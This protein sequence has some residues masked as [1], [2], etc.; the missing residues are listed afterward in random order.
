MPASK[1]NSSR[2]RFI[3]Y[4]L[5]VTIY[6]L[7]IFYLSSIPGKEIPL[8]FAHQ[9]VIAHIVEYAIFAILINRALKAYNL[10]MVYARRLFWVFLLSFVYAVSDE[11]HQIF[12]PGRYA[13]GLDLFIDAIG[14]FIGSLIY[15]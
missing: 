5:P 12:V 2:V 6:A 4:W 7:L 14:S 9:D 11:F 15:R 13:S 1:N 10:R 8:L 3:K